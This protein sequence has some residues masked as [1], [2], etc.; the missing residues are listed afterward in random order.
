[1]VIVAPVM[2]LEAVVA[3]QLYV[4][5]ENAQFGNLFGGV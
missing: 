4:S 3:G 5:A 1:M 2:V